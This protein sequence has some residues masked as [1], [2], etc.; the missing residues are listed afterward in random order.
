[1]SADLT[2]DL[3]PQGSGLR[4][5]SGAGNASAA[6]DV[7]GGYAVVADDENDVL[8]L[9]DLSESGPP[10]QTFDFTGQLP[11]GTSEV[12]VEAAARVG[13]VIYWEGSMSTGSSGD[14]EPARSTVFATSVS[15]TGA[16]T[17]LTY[18]GSYTGLLGDLI[19][20]DQ[21][22][23]N[24]LGLAASAAAG[25]G[26]H[27]ADAL[28]VEGLEFAAGSSSTAYLAFRA[29]LEPTTN[30]HLAMLI[31]VTNFADL[32]TNGNP[33]TTHATFGSPIFFDL[34]GLGIRDIRENADGQ[35]LIVAGTADDS[36]SGFVLYT[37][38]GNPAHAPRQT[39]TVLPQLPSADNLG[40]WE[41]I[42]STPDPL[43][44]GAPVQLLQDDGDVD[45]YGDGLTSKTGTVTDLQK[46][47]GVVF[48]YAAPTPQATAVT[49]TSSANPT[50][51]GKAVT[52]TATV[53]G[54]AD[55]ATPTGSVTFSITGADGS[56]VNCSGSNTVTLG[57]GLATCSLPA[58][59]LRASGSAYTVTASYAGTADDAGSVG[60]L[61]ETVTGAP[62]VTAAA[63]VTL[64]PKAG[65]SVAVLAAVIPTKSV[66]ALLTG[67][68]IFTVTDSS[69]HV[70]GTG[71]AA[72]TPFLPVASFTIPGAA[73]PAA[74]TYS[75]QVRYSGD[76]FYSPSTTS[77][78]LRI[79]RA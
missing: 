27:E 10:V 11:F 34:G 78:S 74:G 17:T 28:N 40:A 59:A 33:G 7:G 13:N 67:S 18:L 41:T 65:R 52:L 48:D 23:G 31:P 77:F 44:S 45:W 38:D 16:N 73:L 56:H 35:Y 6:V 19:A 66:P 15:G 36:N 50:A 75:V 2:G 5:Y 69:G 71:S 43:V 60:T 37:W 64:L 26:G 51:P 58:G 42:V 32:A 70:T 63:A 29:P 3:G 24:A 30:R 1:V 46:D 8:R 54:P 4:Y 39:P 68:V 47:L 61:T 62:T 25:V 20:W 9:Y 22:N 14:L 55:E 76:E 49:V 72:L 12:D 53:S 57:G 21:S 79:S